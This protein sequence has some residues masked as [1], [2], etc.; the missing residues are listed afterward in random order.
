LTIPTKK[1]KINIDL[2]AVKI[3]ADYIKRGMFIFTIY[4]H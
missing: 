1:H 2:P 4:V 3:A